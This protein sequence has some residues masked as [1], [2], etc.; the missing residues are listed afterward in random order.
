[1]L[2]Y[3][4]KIFGLGHDASQY[5]SKIFCQATKCPT[6]LKAIWERDLTISVNELEWN[7]ICQKSKKTVKKYKVRLIQF[8]KFLIASTGHHLDYINETLK[9]RQT[10]RNVRIRRVHYTTVSGSAL[11][12]KNFGN[13]S[14]IVQRKLLTMTL[15]SPLGYMCWVTH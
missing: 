15:I 4:I 10:V 8:L 2:A 13:K 5:Y 7:R 6:A 12:F 3:I 1:M 14:T 11:R 9:T